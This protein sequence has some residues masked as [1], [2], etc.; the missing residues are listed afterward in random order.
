[1]LSRLI[2][3][4]FGIQDAQHLGNRPNVVCDSCFHRRGDTK[5][6]VNATEVVMHI[7]NGDGRD[8]ILNFLR[9]RI[10]QPR[11]AA[12]LHPHREILALN[13]ARRNM[14]RVRIARDNYFAASDALRRAVT[15]LTLTVR[16]VQ[17]DQHGII[18]VGAER[19]FHGAQI[20]A[21]AIGRKLHA[22]RK[23]FRQILNESIGRA[24]ITS[25]NQ[26]RHDE[27]AVSIHR[28][29][30]PYASD[31]E[32]PL[33]LDR[34]VLVFRVAERPNFIALNTLAIQ[35]YES[36]VEVLR[37]RPAKFY[38]KFRNRV[39]GHTRHANCSADAVSLDKSRYHVASLFLCEFVHIEHSTRG[40]A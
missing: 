5:R 27:F 33:F 26:P 2:F 20:C 29:P 15:R 7:V 9:E 30:R 17:F 14:L 39:L 4:L 6:L 36:L 10:G 8:V 28:R 12:H 1:M 37:A 38:E 31:S 34:N 21:M 11:E 16:A 32:L 13:V 22:I 25:T 23:T 18:H 40:Q 3:G 19:I 35:I 24:R